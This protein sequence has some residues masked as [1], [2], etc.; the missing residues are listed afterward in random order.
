[1]PLDNELVEQLTKELREDEGVRTFAYDDATGM[2]VRTLPTG[3]N[4][5]IGIG[6]NLSARGLSDKEVDFLLQ[7]DLWLSYQAAR[8]VFPDFDTY[9]QNRRAALLGL[10][11]N[12]GPGTFVTFKNTIRAIREQRWADA[13]T[14]LLASRWATQIQPSRRDRIVKQ[15]RDG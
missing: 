7:N 8:Q 2:T 13:A 3:G 4:L 11:F 6:R 10:L 9:S 14:N 12:L 5:T 1:M 15:V